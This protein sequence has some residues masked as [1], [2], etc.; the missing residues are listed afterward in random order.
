MY[1]QNNNYRSIQILL[2]YKSQILFK[3]YNENFVQNLRMEF[4]K[5]FLENI[6]FKN[7]LFPA[8]RMFFG[9]VREKNPQMF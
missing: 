8:G 5:Y 3:I 6:F 7:V 9:T 2:E 4:L 1:R